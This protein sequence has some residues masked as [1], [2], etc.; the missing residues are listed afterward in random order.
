METL[1]FV[2]LGLA[3]LGIADTSYLIHERQK[4]EPIACPIGGKCEVV[5]ESK[6][7]KFLGVHLDIWG[8]IYYL[9]ITT[10]SLLTIFT[11]CVLAPTILTLGICV[12]VLTSAM[13][14]LT[15]WLVIKAWCFWCTVSAILS[16]LMGIT[17]LMFH[18]V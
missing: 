9:G 12:G 5:L 1:P 13:L 15:Q 14:V 3:L 10:L 16:F 8:L 2:I 18:Y 4:P 7:N 17:L 6:F 11:S